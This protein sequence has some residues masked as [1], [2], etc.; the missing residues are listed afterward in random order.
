MVTG[1]P[2]SNP[3]QPLAGST[4]RDFLIRSEEQLRVATQRVAAGVAR[5]E[6]FVVT[7]T[8]T[9]TVEVAHEEIRL[10]HLDAATSPSH[11][12]SQAADPGRWMVLSREE[13]VV[14]KQVV[15]MERV[16]PEV[17]PVVEQ[18]QVTE[19]VRKEQV[20][21]TPPPHTPRL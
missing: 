10:V 2:T 16:R 11:S 5:L 8:K 15:P 12:D 9:I 14:T 13:L 7:E 3:V 20:D 1:E 18:Q 19:A 6:K 21:T 17:V 4:D